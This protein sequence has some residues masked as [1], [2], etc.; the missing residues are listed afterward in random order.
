M[1]IMIIIIKPAIPACLGTTT[2]VSATL[3]T[4]IKAYLALN[5]QVNTIQAFSECV[6]YMLVFYYYLFIYNCK[7]SYNECTAMS[8]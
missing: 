1:I 8:K 6:E 7:N 4:C 5:A 2:E 3:Y